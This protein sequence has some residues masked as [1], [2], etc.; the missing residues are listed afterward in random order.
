MP[1]GKRG[2]KDLTQL[3]STGASS[4]LS[5][6]FSKFQKCR[7]SE[8]TEIQ[9]ELSGVFHYSY[10]WMSNFTEFFFMC[11]NSNWKPGNNSPQH[12]YHSLWFCFFFHF[13]CFHL[14]QFTAYS[15]WWRILRHN[16]MRLPSQF[17]L[18]GT[19]QILMVINGILV[20]PFMS[21]HHEGRYGNNFFF[22]F[23]QCRITDFILPVHQGNRIQLWCFTNAW[24]KNKSTEYSLSWRHG[25]FLHVICLMFINDRSPHMKQFPPEIKIL[26]FFLRGFCWFDFSVCSNWGNRTLGISC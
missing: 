9:G 7:S 14:I 20:L 4:L 2:L 13:F 12:F 6:N 17:G 24:L 15:L 25:I 18:V 10:K 21:E 3:V 23:L 16:R 19:A 5:L 8:Q 1:S 11:T 26:I 22:F